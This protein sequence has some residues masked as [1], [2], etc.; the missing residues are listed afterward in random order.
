MALTVGELLQ[1]RKFNP[2]LTDDS[3]IATTVGNNIGIEKIN[4]YIQGILKAVGSAA[5]ESEAYTNLGSIVGRAAAR[6][7]NDQQMEAVRDLY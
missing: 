1:Y 4:D 2:E 5:D 6:K 3:S 7:P